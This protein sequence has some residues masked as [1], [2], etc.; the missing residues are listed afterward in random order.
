M[1]E[2]CGRKVERKTSIQDG[3]KFGQ[4]RMYD[5]GHNPFVKKENDVYNIHTYI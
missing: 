1:V 4:F 3:F 2:R 5:I